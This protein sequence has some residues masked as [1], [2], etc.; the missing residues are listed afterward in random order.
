MSCLIKVNIP[1]AN[2]YIEVSGFTKK[3]THWNKYYKNILRKKKH[4]TK[5][6]KAN[7]E[8]V[9]IKLTLKQIQYVRLNSV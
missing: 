5:K 9:Q 4:I 6:L 2:K 3:W 7:F 1:S 8:F